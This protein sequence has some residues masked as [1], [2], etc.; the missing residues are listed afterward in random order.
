MK[1]TLAVL[2]SF[3][4]FPI[5][6]FGSLGTVLW[7][8]QSGVGSGFLVGGVVAVAIVGMALLERWIPHQ[9]EWNLQDDDVQVDILHMVC[10]QLGTGKVVDLLFLGAIAHSSVW[11]SEV[12]GQGM[13]PSQWPLFFQFLLALIGTDFIRYWL[14]RAS[15]QHPLLWKFHAIHHSPNR[16]YWLNAGR[17][18]PLDELLHSTAVAVPL[19]L[20]GAPEAILALHFVFAAIHGM[21]QHSN[22]DVKL[23]PLNYLFPMAE[24]H[25]WHHS[26]DIKEGTTNFGNNIAL[27][28]LVFGTWYLPSKAMKADQIG[29]SGLEV[30]KGYLGQLRFPF[31][32]RAVS[33]EK[34]GNT[35]VLAKSS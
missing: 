32:H 13:W 35:I 27:W 23:G 33:S 21:F 6:F 28:D 22:I 1:K 29:I 10:T 11:L 16:L 2:A 20:L 5:L 24:L 25:R 9:K 3:L 18:H 17:F 31:Q 34:K 14:H 30:P 12:I 7:G 15:H 4:S 26:R 19:V 8:L